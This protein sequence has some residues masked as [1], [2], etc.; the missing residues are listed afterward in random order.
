MPHAAYQIFIDPDRGSA[1]GSVA[2]IILLSSTHAMRF[3][4]IGQQNRPVLLF[5]HGLSAT[6]E[7]CYGA[8]VSRLEKDWHI[9]L[10]ELGGH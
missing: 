4:E 3:Q 2:C 8:V 1:A 10:C 5:I 7:S 6:A 9:I